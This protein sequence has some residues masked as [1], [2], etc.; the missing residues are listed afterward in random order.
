MIATDPKLNENVEVQRWFA[1]VERAL[2]EKRY[3]QKANFASQM[4]ELY[5]SI[6][7]FGTGCMFI[8]EEIGIG[9][10]YKS[11]FLDDILIDMNHQGA[12]D[13][14]FRKMEMTARQIVQ[15]FS[16]PGDQLPDS[17]RSMAVSK[18]E[19]K[20]ELIHCVKPI[21]ESSGKAGGV[22]KFSSYYVSKRDKMLIREGG[23]R[24]FPYIA[25]RYTVTPNEVY[26]RSPAMAVLP[27]IR[28]LNEME[29]TTIR[30]AHKSIDPPLLLHDDGVLTTMN[31]RPGGINIGGVS[32]DGRQLVQPLQ[33]GANFALG[34][35][36]KDRKRQTINDAFLVSLFQILS[37]N[38]RMTAT[39]V[40]E[41]AQEKGALLSPAMG[42]LQTEALGPLIEREL[43]ILVNGGMV[44]PL[45]KILVEAE[46]EFEIAYDSPLSR[47]QRAEDVV[48]MQRMIGDIGVLAQTDPTLLDLINGDEFARTSAEVHGV[49]TKIIRSPEEVE[50]LRGKRAEAQAAAQKQQQAEQVPQAAKD[51]SEAQKN[52]A[53]AEGLA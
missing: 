27:D 36:Q 8:D 12:L 23:F 34:E 48:G 43:D 42:R 14:V 24:T 20:F 3:A 1:E 10:R 52:T 49:P 32:R 28:M 44:P 13:T 21:E 41:R 17:I 37:D 47:S 15:R 40:M 29:K 25:P 50:E 45:P 5:M 22:F 9:L 31:T 16:Q 30:A 46:G 51:F 6:G 18:P 4:H 38:P 2:F 26:G 19:M 39:E 7:A 35:D 33:T 11:V 53:Q